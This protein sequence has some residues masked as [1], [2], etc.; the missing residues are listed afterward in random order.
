MEVSKRGTLYLSYPI[1]SICVF[2]GGSIMGTPAI[3]RFKVDDSVTEFYR[4]KIPK[5]LSPKP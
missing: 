3:P 5:L 4:W 2:F 1:I